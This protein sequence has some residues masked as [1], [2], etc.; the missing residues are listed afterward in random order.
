M[1]E[2]GLV[3]DETTLR[4]FLKDPHNVVPVARMAFAGMSE[5]EI[6]GFIA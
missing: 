6:T 4:P 2:S 5:Q 3:S 1:R